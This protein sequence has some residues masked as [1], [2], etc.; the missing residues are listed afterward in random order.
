MKLKVCG[1]KYPDN[2]REL[3]EVSPDFMGM[4]FFPE[5]PRFFDQLKDA[6]LL[7]NKIERVGVFVNDPVS[8]VNEICKKF[9]IKYVQLH[10]NESPNDCR[11]LKNSGYIVIKV[12]PVYD[13]LPINLEEYK[14]VADL[15]LF[16][17]KTNS[18]GGSGKKFDWSILKKYDNEVPLILSGG[19]D[20]ES[21]DEIKALTGVNIFAVDINSRF[22]SE[23]GRKDI[24]KIKIFKSRLLDMK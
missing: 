3:E 21:V 11:E 5:S 15:F 12:F 17:T 6:S 18:H 13:K 1:M 22:E 2:I 10:G 14:A 9:N 23:P 8:Q 20:P 16:D 4:I 19:I 7:T 24:E